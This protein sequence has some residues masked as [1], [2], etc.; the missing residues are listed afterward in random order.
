MSFTDD[1]L[2]R[3]ADLWDHMLSHP[4]LRRAREGSL[5]DEAFR[6]WL[7]QDYHFVRAARPFLGVLLDRAPESHRDF[8]AD[9]L[10]ALG[11]ELALFRE[12]ARALEVPLQGVEPGL[13]NHAYVHFLVA[14]AHRADYRCALTVYYV[15]E[16]AYHESWR[17]VAEGTEDRASPWQPLIRNWAGAAFG[18]FVAELGARLDALAAQSSG[19]DRRRMGELFRRT[20]VYE[21]A[22]WQMAV[23]GP[24]WPGLPERLSPP[25][26]RPEPSSK[27]ISGD[28]SPEA[29]GGEDST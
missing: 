4:F 12:Q 14:T 25:T 3:H 1:Q 6:T 9:A 28:G 27:S 23:D 22:F 2:R 8:L 20:I 17:V 7:R 29:G 5:P 10:A 24:R 18:E 13:V 19:E 11:D 15:A 26:P 21:I 16:R